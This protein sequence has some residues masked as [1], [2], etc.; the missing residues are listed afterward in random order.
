MKHITKT[1]FLII[2]FLI[3][4][5]GHFYLGKHWKGISLFSIIGLIFLSGFIL[6]D[7]Q[8]LSFS[9]EPKYFIIQMFAGIFTFVALFFVKNSNLPP[10]YYPTKYYFGC[11]YICLAGIL[12]L[13]IFIDIL[14]IYNVKFREVSS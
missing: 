2:S 10:I 5:F 11:F 14:N 12:N 1:L 7:Y 9:R 8:N 3:P 6:G 4:G 13:I